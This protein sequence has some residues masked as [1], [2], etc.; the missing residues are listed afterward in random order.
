MDG[1]PE[2]NYINDNLDSVAT[3][4]FGQKSPLNTTVIQR[5]QKNLQQLGGE[6]ND[7]KPFADLL[8]KFNRLTGNYNNYSKQ[9]PKPEG[10][11]LRRSKED[12]FYPE[13]KTGMGYNYKLDAGENF[14]EDVVYYSKRVPNTRS[15]K[16]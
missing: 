15:R 3:I 7:P 11:R 1:V 14:T 2:G 13:Y 10:F 5:I 8:V 6:A 16:I 4:M 12:T 9:I